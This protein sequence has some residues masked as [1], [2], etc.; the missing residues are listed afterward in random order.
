[1]SDAT[2]LWIGHV[3][4]GALTTGSMSAAIYDELALLIP[5][6]DAED[7]LPRQQL[8]IA[9]ANG[10]ICHLQA[11]AQAFHVNVA[12]AGPQID[13]RLAVDVGDAC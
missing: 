2:K 6:R 7:P 8:A 5:L 9:I 10:V 12:D 13:R 4:S 1:M 3:E 11:H